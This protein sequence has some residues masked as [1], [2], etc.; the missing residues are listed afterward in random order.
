MTSSAPIIPAPP[1][2]EEKPF[3]IRDTL[4]VFE[5]AM[6]YAARHPHGRFLRGASPED[7]L[8]FLKAWIERPRRPARLSWEVYRD[9]LNRIERGVIRP[10]RTAYTAKGEI[11]TVR[12]VLH[13]ADLAQLA[14]ERNERQNI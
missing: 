4:T 3:K 1:F 2:L 11:D 12:T 5:A 9:M 8:L 14:I 6:V 13:I 7:R 10:L